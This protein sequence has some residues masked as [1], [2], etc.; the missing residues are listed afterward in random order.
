MDEPT[1]RRRRFPRKG[2]EELSPEE[3]EAQEGS[4]LPDREA[5]S[6]I[7]GDVSIPVDPGVA[8]DVLLDQDDADQD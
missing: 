8:A 3:L 7:Q 6:I 5:L 2:D 4:A 1:P